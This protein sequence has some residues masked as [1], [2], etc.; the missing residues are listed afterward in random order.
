[1]DEP[2]VRGLLE[3]L[4]HGLCEELSADRPVSALS[5]D[6][7]FLFDFEVESQPVRL[8]C[9][10]RLASMHAT[11]ACPLGPVPPDPTQ[12]KAVLLQLLRVSQATAT[13][14]TTVGYEPLERCLYLLHVVPL[15]TA[16]ARLLAATMA[17][18]AS[19]A[20]RWRDDHFLGT[21]SAATDGAVHAGPYA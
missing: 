9:D 7:P 10:P 3:R 20:A 5:G 1:M 19:M 15:Q 8:L 2:P 11:L 4:L 13:T 6:G 12:A 17:G 14:G 16:S 18:L 21:Q